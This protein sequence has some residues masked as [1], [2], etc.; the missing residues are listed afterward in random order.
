MINGKQ[1][2][3]VWYVDNNK[4]SNVDSKVNYQVPAI[5]EIRFCRLVIA[6]GK[7]HY[8]LGMNLK[9]KDKKIEILIKDQLDEAFETFGENL[10]GTV[11]S[12]ATR[13]L[14]VVDPTAEQLEDG[15]SD[16]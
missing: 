12:P 16:I 9:I 10:S 8:F 7:E 3:I 13:K 4:L 2:T 15:K 6:G 1:S 5:M 14:I 11:L